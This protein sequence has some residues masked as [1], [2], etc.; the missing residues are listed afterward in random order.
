[1][2]WQVFVRE[3]GFAAPIITH[4]TTTT[5][6]GA[7]KGGPAHEASRPLYTVFWPPPWYHCHLPLPD[8]WLDML[9]PPPVDGTAGD[10]SPLPAVV[11]GTQEAGRE[12]DGDGESKHGL[13]AGGGEEEMAAA[14][15]AAAAVRG[16][17]GV[18]Q[19]ALH[20][21][22][23]RAVWGSDTTN[24]EEEEGGSGRAVDTFA[25]IQ[26]RFVFLP[27]PC[28]GTRWITTQL[29]ILAPFYHFTR[30]CSRRCGDCRGPMAPTRFR[31]LRSG[32]RRSIARC[33]WKACC[34]GHRCPR[35]LRRYKRL[36]VGWT[37]RR[38]R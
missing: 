10:G 25:L 37:R 29:R 22:A 34:C 27:V 14:A 28:V 32:M 16:W 30:P 12:M 19:Q 36:C 13:M 26:V 7:T 31:R 23:A 3:T 1:M 8:V 2:H 17:R 20:T 21:P 15:A 35:G 6:A 5:A 9:P 18:L 11:Q 4:A 38:R 24:E 33:W